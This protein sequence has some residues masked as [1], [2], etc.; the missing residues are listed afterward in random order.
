[1]HSNTSSRPLDI[2]FPS[3]SHLCAQRRGGTNLGAQPMVFWGFYSFWSGSQGRVRC[4]VRCFGTRNPKTPP[5]RTACSSY[6]M[7]EL[8]HPALRSRCF[9]DQLQPSPS[10]AL[11]HIRTPPCAS[12]RDVGVGGGVSPAPGPTSNSGLYPP[13]QPRCCIQDPGSFHL[14]VP[15]PNLS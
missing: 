5:L 13:C 1:M 7:V 3:A 11:S 6:E 8:Q 4:L 14:E 15:N 10:Y 2:G 12:Q 9:R